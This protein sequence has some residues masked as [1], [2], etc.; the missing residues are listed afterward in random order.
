M[1]TVEEGEYPYDPFVMQGMAN[2]AAFLVNLAI[3]YSRM[4]KFPSFRI[5]WQRFTEGAAASAFYV[6]GLILLLTGF[7]TASSGAA[8]TCGFLALPIFVL[9]VLTSAAIRNNVQE[10]HEVEMKLSGVTT[11]LLLIITTSATLFI[12]N[13]SASAPQGIFFL[14]LGRCF[15]CIKSYINGLTVGARSDGDIIS[16][17]TIFT[18]FMAV[19][20][21]TMSQPASLIIHGEASWSGLIPSGWTVLTIVPF[22][23]STMM[24]ISNT[25]V[26]TT[27]SGEM[28]AITGMSGR[29]LAMYISFVYDVVPTGPVV[30]SVVTISLAVIAY[31]RLHYKLGGEDTQYPQISYYSLLHGRKSP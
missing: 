5:G 25:L 30:L 7:K 28:Q 11:E 12:L 6:T 23:S 14:L 4:R 29:M 21:Y 10:W 9:V 24:Y 1:I 31:M 26:E 16:S 17:A 27:V 18:A 13:D 15:I 8:A 3:D 2:G 22:L 20:M 19:L